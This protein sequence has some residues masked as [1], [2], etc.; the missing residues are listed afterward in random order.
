MNKKILLIA[1][2]LFTTSII[3]LGC[4]N[5]SVEANSNKQDEEIKSEVIKDT[6]TNSNELIHFA[7][8]KELEDALNDG[9]DATGAMVTFDAGITS[10][11]PN[12]YLLYSGKKLA[13][14][15]NS[16]H[17][18]EPGSIVTVKIKKFENIE[19]IWNIEYER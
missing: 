18:I 15:S 1:V 13:F 6:K 9:V 7:S 8:A 17:H 5:T 19:G 3:L 10:P 12:S 4:N 14:V 16:H 11:G 2:S